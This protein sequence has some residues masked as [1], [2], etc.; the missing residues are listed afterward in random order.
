[1][2]EASVADWHYVPFA[3][4]LL[5]FGLPHGA[6]D[7][8]VM[9]D[10]AGVEWWSWRGLAAI[11]GY[12][13]LAGLV[14]ALWFVAPVA[15]FVFFIAMTWY[16]WGQG[17]VWFMAAQHRGQPRSPQLRA[18]GLVVRGALPMLLPFI[19]FPEVYLGVAD[20]LAALF[21]YDSAR[22]LRIFAT[23]QARGALGAVFLAFA[24]AYLILAWR[25]A[26]NHTAWLV[27]AGEV[28][29][30]T[31]F[32]LMVPPILSVGLFFCL[33]HAPRH[34]IRLAAELGHADEKRAVDWRGLA[35]IL[36]RS[37]PLTVVSLAVLAGISWWLDVSPSDP[38][39]SLAVYLALIAAVTFPHV[40]V[41]TA[42]DVRARLFSSHTELFNAD[43]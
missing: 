28:S 24:G 3:V 21:G 20:Q 1:M 43:P 11:L 36:T 29:L 30:L 38:G 25:R 6:V 4:S 32:F 27:D 23:W 41:V 15:T 7:H 22:A 13:V 2:L 12:L 10:L 14:F 26:P 19:A 35:Q 9:A 18:L 34:L 8:L 5:V 17:E 37:I 39:R 31:A 40:L 33:W 42:M 16:H